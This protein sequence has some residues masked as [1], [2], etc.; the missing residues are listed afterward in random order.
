VQTKNLF[1]NNINKFEKSIHVSSG[2]SACFTKLC[3]CRPSTHHPPHSTQPTA[4]PIRTPTSSSIPPSHGPHRHLHRPHPLRA[5]HGCRAAATPP[6]SSCLPF[7]SLPDRLF[8]SA[9]AAVNLAARVVPT[10][11]EERNRSPHFPLRFPP[12]PAPLWSESPAGAP[13]PSRSPL[14]HASE[15]APGLSQL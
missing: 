9:P 3:S 15:K 12:L 2:S 10:Q 4:T 6:V 13:P 1:D 14:K 11:G 8:S 7:S 5:P